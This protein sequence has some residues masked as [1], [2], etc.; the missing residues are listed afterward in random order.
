M[1]KKIKLDENQVELLMLLYDYL[2]NDI[3]PHLNPNDVVKCRAAKIEL[4][5]DIDELGFLPYD[6]EEL[7]EG[8]G[9]K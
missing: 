9:E 7:L 5:K 2:D 6:L 1:N 4:L 3:W 8:L